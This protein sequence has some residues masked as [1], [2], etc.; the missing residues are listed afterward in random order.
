MASEKKQQ[1][2]NK[3]RARN[4][5]NAPEADMVEEEADRKGFF[6]KTYHIQAKM[7]CRSHLIIGK[8]SVVTEGCAPISRS[9]IASPRVPRVGRDDVGGQKM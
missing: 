5:K 3:W 1:Q 4:E 9:E 8:G 7:R 6:L 2:K